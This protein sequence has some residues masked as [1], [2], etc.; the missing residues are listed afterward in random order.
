MEHPAHLR[1]GL[2]GFVNEHQVVLGHVIEQGGRSLAGQAAAEMAR[3]VFDAVA[4]ADGAHH[5]DVEQSALRDTLSFNK[6]S[7]LLDRK[8][9][10]LNSSHGYISYAVFCLKKKKIHLTAHDASRPFWGFLLPPGF[11]LVRRI[12][13]EPSC[14]PLHDT[15]P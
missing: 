11:R 8:S 12:R 7:L 3:I 6:F 10:R 13:Y 9:T 15:V 1:N 2:V 5:F 14:N 4:V